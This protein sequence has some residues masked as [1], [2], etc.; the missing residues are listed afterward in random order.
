ML[1]VDVISPLSQHYW[2]VLT[3]ETQIAKSYEAPPATRSQNIFP[4]DAIFKHVCQNI[5]NICL[6]NKYANV[7]L[8]EYFVVIPITKGTHAECSFLELQ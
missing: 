6:L 8:R 7:C 3:N 5:G 1:T 2:T 4:S